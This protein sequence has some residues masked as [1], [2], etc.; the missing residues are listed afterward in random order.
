MWWGY[1]ENKKAKG[2][3]LP[4]FES[5]RDLSVTLEILEVKVQIGGYFRGVNN[6]P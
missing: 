1:F 4:Q 5:L 6:F 2:V 3:E